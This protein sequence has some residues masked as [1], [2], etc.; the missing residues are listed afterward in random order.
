[1]SGSGKSR[2]RPRSEARR[3]TN[4]CT[5]QRRLR[6]LTCIIGRNIDSLLVPI[7]RQTSKCSLLSLYFTIH[8]EDNPETILYQSETIDD[9]LN[10]NWREFDSRVFSQHPDINKASSILV[11]VWGARRT[12]EFKVIL[13]YN[14]HFSGLIYSREQLRSHDQSYETNCLMFR[15]FGGYYKTACANQNDLNLRSDEGLLSRYIKVEQN[16][17]RLSYK[18]ASLLRAHF[19]LKAIYQ[20]RQQVDHVKKQMEE[21][22]S[23]NKLRRRKAADREALVFKNNL[24]KK[25]LARLR[26]KLLDEKKSSTS[27]QEAVVQQEK[28]L[29]NRIYELEQYISDMKVCHS[30]HIERRETLLKVNAHLNFRRR[31]LAAE[32]SY[33]YPIVVLPLRDG[34]KGEF[35]VNGVRLPNSEEFIGED[36][37]ML[38]V[39]LGNV[40]HLVHM[41][42]KFLELPLRYPIRGLGSRSSVV[43]FVTDKLT[44]KQREFPLYSKGK[45]KFQFHYGVFLL[46]KNIAQLR[47]H[48]GL[49]TADLRNTLPNLK[50]LLEAKYGVRVVMKQTQSTGFNKSAVMATRRVTLPAESSLSAE[51]L[52]MHSAFDTIDA[53][54][55]SSQLEQPLGRPRSEVLSGLPS[56]HVKAHH[57]HRFI[58]RKST[59]RKQR[60]S[61]T[62]QTNEGSVSPDLIEVPIEDVVK[63]TIDGTLAK[64]KNTNTSTVHESVI[65]CGEDCLSEENNYEE[66][67]QQRRVSYSQQFSDALI[68]PD[69]FEREVDDPMSP[70]GDQMLV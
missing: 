6:H 30:A 18:K 12:K 31:Q 36:D 37:E 59:G 17:V 63:R 25:E 66:D 52:S 41:I 7:T 67:R 32:L 15:M 22:L 57:Q 16:Q 48:N 64:K 26:D 5:Q 51:R 60:K 14:V 10:P 9:T 39:A 65:D 40:C 62:S 2:Y 46:N 13:S 54:E 8:A 58:A 69:P 20:T 21:N 1:M 49:G 43:D 55:N 50:Q 27:K 61:N 38:S 33:I 3:H 56:V 24:L 44:E 4:L 68:I 53:E 47:Y 70:G 23:Q 29:N 45:E 42:A 19:T 28:D 11:H 34:H 35:A